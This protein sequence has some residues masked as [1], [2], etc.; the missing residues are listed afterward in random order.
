MPLIRFRTGD[1]TFKI[2]EPCS[3]GRQ[4]PRIGPILGRKAQMLKCKGTTLFPQVV[5]SAL[6]TAEEVL[7]Y[8]VVVTG[9]DLSDHLDVYVALKVPGSDLQ[10]IREKLKA[11]CR[12][13][14]QGKKTAVYVSEVTNEEGKLVATMNITGFI[15]DDKPIVQ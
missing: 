8:Y 15:V 7:D 11:V 3:C 9:E 10:P 12:K 1:I 13:V 5:F 4:T 2:T 6:D 14:S